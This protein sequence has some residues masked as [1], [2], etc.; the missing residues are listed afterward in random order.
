MTKF[1]NASF[2]FKLRGKLISGFGNLR[3]YFKK[4]KHSDLNIEDLEI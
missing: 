1:R 2:F 3:S 4:S